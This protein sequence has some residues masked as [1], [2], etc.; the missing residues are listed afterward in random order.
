MTVLLIVHYSWRGANHLK[1]SAHFLDL[2]RLLL[3][4]CGQGL[5][6]TFLGRNL[7]RLFLGRGL[8]LLHGVTLFDPIFRRARRFLRVRRSGTTA[9][10]ELAVRTYANWVAGDCYTRDA[11][12]KA[13]TNESGIADP[14]IAAFSAATREA[15]RRA[16][17][18]V[19]AAF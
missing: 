14:D 17:V 4:R 2:V 10:A 6:L 1:L 3:E 12:D 15:G 9:Y 7:C 16:D 5:D 8:Q 19:I 13:G 18:D 11:G